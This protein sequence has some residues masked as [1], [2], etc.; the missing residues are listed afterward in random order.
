MYIGLIQPANIFQ[1]TEMPYSLV[2]LQATLFHITPIP[3]EP[4]MAS[5][6]LEAAQNLLLMQYKARGST[7]N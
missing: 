6:V 3:C 1:A 7:N 5:K 4:T 2:H